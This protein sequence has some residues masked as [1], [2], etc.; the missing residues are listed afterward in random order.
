[1]EIGRLRSVRIRGRSRS[2]RPLEHRNH[3]HSH[4][5]R[6]ALKLWIQHNRGAGQIRTPDHTVRLWNVK[7][8]MGN[9]VAGG[10]AKVSLARHHLAHP[11]RLQGRYFFLTRSINSVADLD[12]LP[13]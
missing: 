12:F 5:L 6:S 8:Q 10:V 9:P 4:W 2:V 7:H 11:P 3:E 13:S 1:M